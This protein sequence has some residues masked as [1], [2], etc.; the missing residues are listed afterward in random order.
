MLWE[1]SLADIDLE[2][3]KLL[4][5]NA[6]DSSLWVASGN[7]LVHLD[8]LGRKLNEINVSGRIELMA[9]AL[10]ESLWLYSKKQIW[11]YA[12]S[13]TLISSHNP[14]N[15]FK[16]NATYLSVDSLNNRLWVAS[17]SQLAQ[18]NL[19]LMGQ[20]PLM[21]NLPAPMELLVL[22]PMSGMLWMA[23]QT[24]LLAYANGG[25]IKN[26]E[27]ASLGID[28][29]ESIA[30]DSQNMNLWLSH[31]SGI[32]KMSQEGVALAT[33]PL[34]KK[35]KAIGVPAFLITPKLTLIQPA[36]STNINNNKPTFL[37]NLA[38]MCFDKPCGFAPTRYGNYEVIANLNGQ[39]VGSLF[40]V[41][42]NTGQASYTPSQALPEG[43][44][45]FTA[46]ARDRFGH[47]SNLII[48]TFTIDTATLKILDVSPT[49]GSLL[50]GSQLVV[51]GTFLGPA[52]TG[53][54]V[55]SVVA[56]IS[57]DKFYA[58]VPMQAG[59]NIISIIATTPAGGVAS[60]TVSV[61]NN[62]LASVRISANPSEGVA[63]LKVAFNIESTNENTVQSVSADFD[64][65]GSIDQNV[66]A[67][68]LAM[69]HSYS[70]PGVFLAKF[71]ISDNQGNIDIAQ[72]IVVVKDP[73][74]MDTQFRSIWDGMN[75]AL[76]AQDKRK[77]LSYLNSSA[78][79]K[80]EP[81]FTA[82]LPSYSS[83]VGS[84]SAL[85]NVSVTSTTGEYAVNRVIDGIDQIFFIY[86][87][88][89]PDGVWRL[90]SM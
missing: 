45:T 68:N 61:T 62:G 48:T 59:Q 89:D 83:I 27:L 70:V 37:L 58:N 57:G 46:Q 34:N 25:L 80:Y 6:Y 5:F 41:D 85:Q 3:S 17:K 22:D 54:T 65:N 42:I 18:Y 52:N 69:E 76:V 33:I 75:A 82:L 31:K 81:V 13:G 67:P 72:L 47:V 56:A 7:H 88:R 14:S 36:E 1:R 10:D 35:I 78:R 11:H 90:D 19:A 55:N 50:N 53:I 74:E 44:N 87:L 40:H 4:A 60:R 24:R 66:N 79:V 63:P 16:E 43:R 23:G 20:S 49:D 30:Y 64:G 86:F 51:S 26:I 15:V 39:P 28:K 8:S 38:S 77:A 32:T 21:V 29:P 84:Y 71:E 9:I 73:V 2:D 12:P